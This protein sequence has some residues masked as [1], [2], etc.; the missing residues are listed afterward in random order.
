VSTPEMAISQVEV[1]VQVVVVL[2]H[3]YDDGE[4]E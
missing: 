3:R 4:E 1:E 2:A